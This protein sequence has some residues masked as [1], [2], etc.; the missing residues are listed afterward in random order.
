MANRFKSAGTSHR[1]DHAVIFCQHGLIYT[2]APNALGALLEESASI[3]RQLRRIQGVT[4]KLVDGVMNALFPPIL[5]AEV[6]RV[7]RPL[8]PPGPAPAAYRGR[9]R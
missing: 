3:V 1:R 5:L 6:A 2:V 9:I 7:M 4:V 8:P